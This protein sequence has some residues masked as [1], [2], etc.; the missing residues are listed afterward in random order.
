MRYPVFLAE[1]FAE[2]HGSV[3]RRVETSLCSRLSM[4]SSD[5]R[6]RSESEEN[7]LRANSGRSL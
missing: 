6:S 4:T 2:V 7:S 3:A 1:A 5:W